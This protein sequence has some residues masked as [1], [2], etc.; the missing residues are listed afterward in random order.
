M[1]KVT[2][3]I[4]DELMAR[5]GITTNS[6][7]EV[8]ATALKGVFDRADKAVQLEG[9]VTNLNGTITNLTNERDAA[10]TE[11]DNLKKTTVTN[12]VTE[13]LDSASVAKKI[14]NEQ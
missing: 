6:S 5:V 13:M 14:T 8:D 12:Q 4:S 11:R 10:V 3:M 1:K 7:G 9:Q 2:F